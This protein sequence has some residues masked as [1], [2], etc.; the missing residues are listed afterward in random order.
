M[1]EKKNNRIEDLRN[2]YIYLY[3]QLREINFQLFA[4][5]V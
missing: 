2:R 3:D 5:S 1:E 4:F